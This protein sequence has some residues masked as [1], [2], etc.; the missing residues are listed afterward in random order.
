MSEGPRE[1]DE[2][3]GVYVLAASK[4]PRPTPFYVGHTMTLRQRWRAHR[5]TWFDNPGEEW[6][7]PKSASW[8]IAD[9]VAGINNG[10]LTPGYEIIGSDVAGRRFSCPSRRSTSSG[11]GPTSAFPL[12]S[13]S[14]ERLSQGRHERRPFGV[15]VALYDFRA[16]EGG[17]AYGREMDLAVTYP[18][19]KRFVAQLKMG[20]Y[21]ADQ[22]ATDTTKG[23]LVVNL[24]ALIGVGDESWTFATSGVAPDDKRNPMLKWLAADMI[25][26]FDTVI[27]EIPSA[28]RGAHARGWDGPCELPVSRP[29]H[30][31]RVDDSRSTRYEECRPA[32][33][34]DFR[35]TC[36]REVVP[37]ADR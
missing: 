2:T 33:R 6:A 9:P 14:Q 29:S 15:A 19:G 22:H 23:W 31:S 4:G 20:R 13:Q 26:S 18:V 16:A 3:P 21:F 11:A 28:R 27:R 30:T 8:F 34:P 12:R 10:D 37:P 17:A 1:T 7:N 25:R 36:W 35:E 5:R 24:P 32:R